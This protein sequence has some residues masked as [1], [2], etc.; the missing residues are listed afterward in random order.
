MEVTA[1][2]A[3][4]IPMSFSPSIIKKAVARN[5]GLKWDKG[6]EWSI[7]LLTMV[8]QKTFRSFVIIATKLS[9]TT[10]FVLTNERSSLL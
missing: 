2:V 1:L 3:V 7:G 6:A 8:F 10:G 5:I 9:A 4:K